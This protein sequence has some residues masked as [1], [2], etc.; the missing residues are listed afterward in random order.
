[1]VSL[2]VEQ[3]RA[4][5]ADCVRP[6]VP[7]TLPLEDCCGMVLAADLESVL[8]VPP[9]TNSAMDGFAVRAADLNADA[10]TLLPV[11][12]D[13]PAGTASP[14]P[15]EAGSA[16][17]IMTGA[18]VPAG[19]DTVVKVEL[20]DH[21]GRGPAPLSVTIDA[22]APHF[23]N[24]RRRGEAL[25]VGEVVLRAGHVLDAAALSAAAAV[26]HGALRVRPRPR[27]II[28]TTG[29]EL[30][31]P[32]A[33]PGPGHIPDSN[34][35]LLRHL[36]EHSGGVV[37]A[38]IRSSDDPGELRAALDACPEADLAITAGGISEGAHEVVRQV[39]SGGGLATELLP[40]GEA[41][42]GSVSFHR[43]AQQPG[44]PQGVGH[45]ELPRAGQI[46]VIC[47]PGNPVSVYVTFHV[48]VR[49]MIDCLRG[50]SEVAAAPDTIRVRAAQGWQCPAKK[51]QF[52]PLQLVDPL[53][54]GEWSAAGSDGTPV[55]CLPLV[56][57][58]HPLGSK[59]H[60]VTSLAH[61][62]GLGVIPPGSAGAANRVEAGQVIDLIPTR[63][64]WCFTPGPP[65]S[66]RVEQEHR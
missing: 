32:G 40:E 30:V 19:A 37:V 64:S 41:T 59:S 22:G 38:S 24:I 29:T 63:G 5:V 53:T 66:H 7:A 8:P 14:A 44:G 50:I 54:E 18:P 47:L 28:V 35:L 3:Y 52:I 23:A 61:A 42:K 55:T 65:V 12:A 48:Y 13:I 57:P 21:S 58:V 15:M 51:V 2:T 4:L 60:L 62:D 6:L 16:A 43:V 11:S 39:L 49:A 33:L 31:P 26:G 46:P 36:V 27:V 10:P 34:S 1:M 45:V 25:Q 9:F 17:R 56:A 20:T